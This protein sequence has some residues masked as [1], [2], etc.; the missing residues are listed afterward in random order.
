MDDIRDILECEEMKDVVAAIERLKRTYSE[1]DSSSECMTFTQL[2]S[3][4]FQARDVLEILTRKDPGDQGQL[5]VLAAAFSAWLLF[6]KQKEIR[7]S[8]MM[9]AILNH[10]DAAERGAGL[11]N[12]NWTVERD[13]VARYL[14]TG[15]KFLRD[16][17]DS[18]G[19]YQAFMRVSA[20]GVLDQVF[21]YDIR[22]VRTVA[23]AMRYMHHGALQFYE[24]GHHRRPS[25]NRAAEVFEE[26]KKARKKLPANTE[27][28]PYEHVA[29]SMLHKQWK[30]S[31]GAL[32]LVYAASC[33]RA[34]K[35]K[36]LLD[37]LLEASFSHTS[38]GHLISKWLGM[39]RYAAD[40][41]F[42]KMNDPQLMRNTDRLLLGVEPIAFPPR[43]LTEDERKYFKSSF[44]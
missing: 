31:R 23:H 43:A 32:A 28:P 18:A 1:P 44:L 34:T 2:S 5:D 24:G 11:A 21:E 4:R 41:I 39:A 15:D 36:S 16:M 30:E 10:M 29:R 7:Y 27:V 26:F 22:A 19:G 20:H 25:V 3:G 13:I 33:M 6:P 12:E 35:V 17:Y 40:Y 37:V 14:L 42:S 8:W 38:H 9:H